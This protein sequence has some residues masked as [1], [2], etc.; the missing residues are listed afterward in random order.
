MYATLIA[1]CDFNRVIGSEND[2]PWKIKEDMKH[3]KETTTGN[4]IIM[5]RKTWQSL[6][7]DALPNRNNIVITR[8]AI[9]YRSRKLE[10]EFKDVAF[11]HDLE[12]ALTHCI[13]DREI[14]I[15]GGGQIYKEA[16]EKDFCNRALISLVKRT[17][18]GDAYLPDLGVEWVTDS[19]I[20]YDD[21]TL[22]DMRKII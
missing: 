4:N 6:G 1:A 9:E 15:I 21:F 13:P 10:G 3:F 14:F 12:E 7:I 17:F 22:L 2:I 5:G 11:V 16:I 20:D 18:T 19:V 8:H